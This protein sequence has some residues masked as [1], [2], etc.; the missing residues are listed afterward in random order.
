MRRCK[1]NY[2]NATQILKVANIP[3]AQR[4]RILEK[5]VQKGLHEKIQ[6]GY[7]RFQGTWI[8]LEVG[9]SLAERYHISPEMA[10]ILHFVPDPNNPVA[11]KMKPVKSSLSRTSSNIA[12][13]GANASGTPNA[14]DNGTSPAKKPRKTYNTKKRR[15]EAAAR[16][17]K[18]GEAAA[19]A[20]AT[21]TM[22]TIPSDAVKANGASVKLNGD[23][24]QQQQQ[25]P[26]SNNQEFWQH[27]QL[28]QQQTAMASPMYAP[29]LQQTPT[30]A[31]VQA[32]VKLAFQQQQ[33]QQP[34]FGIR[35]MSAPQSLQHP[36]LLPPQFQGY[37]TPV[38]QPQYGQPYSSTQRQSQP[39]QQQQKQQQLQQQYSNSHTYQPTSFQQPSYASSMLQ[40]LQQQQQQQ[41][42]LQLQLQPNFQYKQ[43]SSAPSSSANRLSDQTVEETVNNSQM[44]EH[45]TPTSSPASSSSSP[46]HSQSPL[47]ISYVND[48]VDY[49]KSSSTV[50]PDSLL[51]PPL[52]FDFNEPIDEDGNTALHWA[53]S[54]AKLEMAKLLLG[55]GADP[56]KYNNDGVNCLSGCVTFNNSYNEGNFDQFLELMKNCLVSDPNGKTPLHYI[57]D[58]DLKKLEISKYYLQCVVNFL[59]RNA[60]VQYQTFFASH[61]DANNMTA[62]DY[63]E[64]RGNYELVKMLETLHENQQKSSRNVSTSVK[65]ETPDSKIDYVDGHAAIPADTEDQQQ[66]QQQQQTVLPSLRF[67]ETG[68]MFLSMLGSVSDAFDSEFQD[69]ELEISGAMDALAKMEEDTKA[70]KDQITA[71]LSQFGQDVTLKDLEKQHAILEKEI[72]DK[73]VQ[74]ENI[75]ERDQ[76]R[77]LAQ[78]VLNEE[79]QL[80]ANGESNPSELKDRTNAALELSSLQEQRKS[81]IKE[82]TNLVMNNGLN[83]KMNKYRK[84][85]SLSVKVKE[86]DVEDLLQGLED[87][88]SAAYI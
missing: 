29:P 40:P 10:P 8:P 77:I 13:K 78:L 21:P 49:F 58:S 59:K 82:I 42:Q 31:R 72:Q 57:C 11:R 43:V 9:Q 70:T 84:L 12:S 19:A 14:T 3:K 39:L 23:F 54:L 81:H 80:P 63:A 76:A 87:D 41:L 45:E 37:Q 50:I 88:L 5:E 4:T 20:A 15:E 55:Y 2:I 26:V 69:V 85:I 30:Q 1:D 33:H 34:H 52:G 46:S 71:L 73:S 47:Q 38:S 28:Q 22:S 83:E 48:L 53:T 61:L 36:G 74:L 44:T 64:K 60:S 24:P 56:T 67:A 7:G 65:T 32:Q 18:E 27:Q 6:G 17:L 25:V 75:L 51:S 68:P 79:S 35:P 66:Q 86:E 16:A 62:A